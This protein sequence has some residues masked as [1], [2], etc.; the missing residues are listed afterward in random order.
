MQKEANDKGEGGFDGGVDVESVYEDHN[1]DD[2]VGIIYN[3]VKT[4]MFCKVP[5]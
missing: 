3:G 1:S 2:N 5:L 4:L